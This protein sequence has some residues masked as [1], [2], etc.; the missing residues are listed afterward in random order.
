MQTPVGFWLGFGTRRYFEAPSDLQVKIIIR[1]ELINI[2][3]VRLPL[4][5]RPKV[6]CGAAN[7]QIGKVLNIV[8]EID[9]R[10]LC[11]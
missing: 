7:Q 5:Q 2:E 11:F 6:G 1:N 8:P 9:A 4:G 3:L 10:Q